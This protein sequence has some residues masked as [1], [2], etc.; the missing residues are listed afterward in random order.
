M[1]FREPSQ[2]VFG[3]RGLSLPGNSVADTGN[4]L[5]HLETTSGLACASCHP[6]GQEDGHV[7]NFTGFGARRTQSL[8]GGLL[9]SEPFH[10]DGAESDFTALTTDVMQGRMGGPVLTAEQTTALAGY[11]DRF[12]ALPAPSAAP[13]SSAEHGKTLFNDP[14]VGCATCHSGARFTNNQTMD[15]G[16]ASG[17]LQVP[18]LVG[19]WARAPYLHDGCAGTLAD[20]FTRCDTGKH[21]NLVG[22]TETDLAALSDYLQTL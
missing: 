15:V 16:N 18:G 8:R 5:F 13:S 10:W 20:R 14:N 17:S 12:P 3:K 9:G 7:W 19:I 22:L 1:Q 21:G 6:E 2:L 11:V 4:T